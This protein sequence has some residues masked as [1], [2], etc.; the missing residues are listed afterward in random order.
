MQSDFQVLYKISLGN[1]LHI[2]CFIVAQSLSHVWLWPH[3][4][5]HTRLLCLPLPPGV[6]SNLC[7]LSHWYYLTISSSAIPFSSCLHSF[8]PSGSFPVNQL[9]A[10]GGKSIGV[11]A[12]ASVLPV[13]IQGWFPLGLTGLIPL[14][15]KGPSRVFS[16]TSIRKH[17][18]FGL[19]ASL[20]SNS[21][22]HTW[23]LEKPNLWLDRPLSAK[24]CLCF[25]IHYVC[26]S[27][28]SK[29]QASF[30]FMAA[31]TTHSG[32]GGESVTTSIFS[33]C[34]CHEILGPDSYSGYSIS[35]WHFVF[36]SRIESWL[37][38]FW[39]P[40]SIRYL[41]WRKNCEEA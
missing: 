23:L 37:L 36:E 34:I 16:N 19:Q 41:K 3:G 40:D 5:Q 29:E 14:Q 8:P 15:S 38:M 18:F 13:N 28:P 32:G 20:W 12:S 6:C 30:N 31:V 21:H 7:P 24:W 27:F 9:F 26:H 4:L 25:L 1:L 2:L 35:T 33:L 10:S 39:V 22:I 17:H 11:W